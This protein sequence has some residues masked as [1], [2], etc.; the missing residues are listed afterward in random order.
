M[1]EREGVR[2]RG[3]ILLKI[4]NLAICTQTKTQTLGLCSK[5]SVPAAQPLVIYRALS[6]NFRRAQGLVGVPLSPRPSS[7]VHSAACLRPSVL[8]PSGQAQSNG[9]QR[10]GLFFREMAPNCC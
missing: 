2:A 5:P 10:R 9:R 6:A 7:S 3:L 4:A 8:K 1:W